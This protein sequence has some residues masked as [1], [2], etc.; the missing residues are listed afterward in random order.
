LLTEAGWFQS[1]ARS[2]SKE[3]Q[4]HAGPDGVQQAINDNDDNGSGGDSDEGEE[5]E[6][7]TEEGTTH[8]PALTHARSHRHRK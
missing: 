1:S 6:E 8:H 5:E 3:R 2:Q 7:A 4:Q